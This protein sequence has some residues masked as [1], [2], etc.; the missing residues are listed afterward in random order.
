VTTV[1]EILRAMT[2]TAPPDQTR[3]DQSQ[4]NELERLTRLLVESRSGVFEAHRFRQ[5]QARVLEM[6]ASQASLRRRTVLVTGGTGCIGS[7]LLH[8]LVARPRDRI[9]SVSRGLTAPREDVPR[10]EYRTLDISHAA[11]VSRMFEAIRPDVVYHL[12]AVRDPALA[13]IEVERTIA[14]NILGTANVIAAAKSVG[15]KKLVYAS[16]GK[17]V[18]FYTG[19]VYAATKKIGERL[20]ANSGL[21]LRSFVR[22]THVVDNSL[23]MQKL[24]TW[25]SGGVVRLHDPGIAFHTQSALESA[26][27]LV[28]AER[29]SGLYTIRDL[30][31]PIAL[32]DLALDV[33]RESG[34]VTPIYFCGYERGY[35]AKSYPGLYDPASGG[36]TG[37]LINALEAYSATTALGDQLNFVP[38][39]ETAYGAWEPAVEALR[40]YCAT[41][42]SAQLLRERLNEISWELL[43]NLMSHTAPV[44]LARMLR[45]SGQYHSENRDH[46]MI[47]EAI[48][49][50]GSARAESASVGLE[51]VDAQPA[52]TQP[53]A[54]R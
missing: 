45:L 52:D 34:H 14:T 43:A 33:M 51:P 11:A 24:A 47:D 48:R 1:S 49:L 32:L 22:Y 44:K 38:A 17:A 5:A 13:E 9:V 35:E 31:W 4:M 16:T 19:D 30:G 8:R 41:G 42:A 2:A 26:Q 37:P 3:L 15:T 28:V 53:V 12:A 20:V 46:Q 23:I 40:A 36:Q 25:C 54:A 6:P 39:S 50:G 7:E 10:V 27:S 29:R 18:R 21:P